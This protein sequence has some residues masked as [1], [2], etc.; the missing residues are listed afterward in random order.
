[1]IKIDPAFPQLGEKNRLV[2]VAVEGVREF[3]RIGGHVP[4]NGV[5]QIQCVHDFILTS[6]CRLGPALDDG[7]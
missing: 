3:R 7:Y 4:R 1:M 5:L 2:Q 6:V